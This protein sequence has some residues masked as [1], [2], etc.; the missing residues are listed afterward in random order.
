MKSSACSI[1]I[2]LSVAIV[3]VS[4]TACGGSSTPVA[5]VATEH[6]YVGNDAAS[7]SILQFALPITSTSTPSVTVAPTNGTANLTALAVDAAGDLA[8]A[9]NAGHLAIFQAPITSSSTASATFSNGTAANNGQLAFNTAGA[10]L[11]ATDS[12]KVNVFNPPLSNTST[13]AQSVTDASLTSAVGVA[14]D[15]SG[16]LLVSNAGSGSSSTLTVF[17]PPFSSVSLVTPAAAGTAYRKVALNT[18]QLFVGSVAG[19]TGQIDVYN[20]PL[21]ASS[22]PVFSMTNVNVPEALA[23]DSHG[24]LYVGNLGD[25][26]IRVFT[27]PFSASSTPTGT[28]TVTGAA[29]FGIAIGK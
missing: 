25:A 8:T 6:L 7:A 17:A 23:F 4:L 16:N 21:S 1:A 28:L 10:L 29:I 15:P 18:N 20:L 3:I 27:P 2:R 11:A 14:L 9:D 12:T 19:S 24:N 22:A 5:P 26:T 13:P